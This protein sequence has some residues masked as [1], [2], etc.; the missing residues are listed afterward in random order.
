MRHIIK[1]KYFYFWSFLIIGSCAQITSPLGGPDDKTPPRLDLEKS[2]PNYQTNFDKREIILTFN[3]WIKVNNPSKEIIISPP[4]D[5]PPQVIEKGKSVIFKFNEKE[6]LKE[7]TTYQINYGDAIKDFTAGN[8]YKNLVFIFAT[9]DVIDSLS[10]SGSVV[11]ALTKEAQADVIVSLYDNLSD[12]AFV[13]TKPLYFTKTDKEGKFKLNNLR[14]DTFQIFA[15]VDKNVSYFYDQQDEEIAFIDSTIFVSDKDSLNI[16]L[17]LFD[18]E[19]IP[20][21]IQAKQTQTGLAKVLYSSPLKDISINPLNSDSTFLHYENESDTIFIWHDDLMADSLSFV[22]E[23]Y[24]LKD[25]IVVRKSKESLADRNVTLEN[26]TRPEIKIHNNDSIKI[27]FPNPIKSFNQD[28]IIIYDTLKAYSFYDLKIEGRS[29]V[30]NVDSL[31][32]KSSYNCEIRP[33]GITDIYNNVNVDTLKN[34]ITTNDPD[35]FGNIELDIVAPKDTQYIIKFMNKTATLDTFLINGSKVI[36]IPRLEKGT[37]KLE[38][39]EDLNKNNYW[40]SGILAEKKHPER[41]KEI[42][43]EELKAG[44]DLK[45]SVD[46]K[47][48]FNGTEIE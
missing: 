19:D 27:S 42:P 15:L 8:I 29:I 35:L 43:L 36:N 25:T 47:S 21:R 26:K 3:E 23:N 24:L 31:Q 4:T 44:W 18:E 12:T 33:G 40:T 17:S 37:Y 2:E 46:I 10:V 34:K 6:V 22:I 11:N 13:K 28:S 16:K 20:R 38:I 32:V 1:Y 9:G 14:S 45:L 5:Y 30:F 48:I 7:N 39:I 41:I